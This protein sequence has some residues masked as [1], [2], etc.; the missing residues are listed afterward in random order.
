[1]LL[2]SPALTDQ[3]DAPHK[4]RGTACC[5]R[6]KAG[7]MR[8]SVSKNGMCKD[9]PDIPIHILTKKGMQPHR[10]NGP[11]DVFGD[12]GK[13]DCVLVALNGAF[14]GIYL[15]RK[16][17]AE[18]QPRFASGGLSIDPRVDQTLRDVIAKQTPF[19]IETRKKLRNSFKVFLETTG[20]YVACAE[21]TLCDGSVDYHAIYID[22][23]RDVVHFGFND[24]GDDM[25]SFLIEKPDRRDVSAAKRNLVTEKNF[26]RNEEDPRRSLRSLRIRDVVQVMLK[27]KML[28]EVPQAAYKFVAPA[29]DRP[30][31][32]AEVES[33]PVA[34]RM[35]SENT[36]RKN[37]VSCETHSSKRTRH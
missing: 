6:P 25:I 32:T 13:L 20:I 26:P 17:L 36:K 7:F 11:I 23:E 2:S 15:T 18:I 31:R 19:T 37:E 12:Y 28:E 33:L 1:M 24:A 8:L 27:V 21:L 16:D 35:R 22:C 9:I 10:R 4:S 3:L 14:G 34:K 30:K 29:V 5:Q